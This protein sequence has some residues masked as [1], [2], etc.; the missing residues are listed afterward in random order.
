MDL[1]H[2]IAEQRA[3][4]EKGFLRRKKTT[5]A[6]AASVQQFQLFDSI[7]TKPA[8]SP[9]GRFKLDPKRINREKAMSKKGTL[10]VG[11]ASLYC[12]KPREKNPA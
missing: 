2:K 1:W 8:K 10:F 4:L 12:V 3:I 5:A 7:R 9:R 6:L 11:F